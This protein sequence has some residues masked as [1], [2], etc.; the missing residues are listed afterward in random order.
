M[1][2]FLTGSILLIIAL[3]ARAQTLETGL[4]I[5]KTIYGNLTVIITM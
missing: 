5:N 2:Q 3:G 4:A 1:K